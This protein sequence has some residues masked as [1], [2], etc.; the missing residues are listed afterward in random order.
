[1]PVLP[2]SCFNEKSILLGL[3]LG[4][5]RQACTILLYQ[6]KVKWECA[7]C[8]VLININKIVIHMVSLFMIHSTW[9]N[10]DVHI[11]YSRLLNLSSLNL[12]ISEQSG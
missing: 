5:T 11:L 8:S 1:M 6:R 2:N 9:H 7:R 3:V 10:F 12:V 4:M